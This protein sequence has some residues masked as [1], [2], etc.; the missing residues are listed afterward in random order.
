MSSTTTKIAELVPNCKGESPLVFEV[1]KILER[2]SNNETALCRIVD[3]TGVI[4]AE[5]NQF[6]QYIV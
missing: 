3:E 1:T 5:F 4:T 2:S 6:V